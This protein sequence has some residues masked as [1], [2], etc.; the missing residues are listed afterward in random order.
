MLQSPDEMLTYGRDSLLGYAT[1]MSEA[2]QAPPH[3]KRIAKALEAVESGK[4]K[5][6]IVTVPP[7]HG[8]SYLCSTYFPAWY[9]GRNPSKFLIAST[10]GQ[11]LSDDFGRKV[12]D[13]LN[14]KLF[15]AIFP[16]AKLRSDSKAA[17]RFETTSG[18][19]YFGVG[20]GGPITGRG[21]HVLFVDDPVKNR[22][23]ADSVTYREKLWDWYRSVAYTRLMPGG[24][25]VIIMTRWHEDDLVGRI[26]SQPGA[27]DWTVV[28][29]PAVTHDNQPLWPAMYN[30]ASL[31][32]I[33]QTV[34][35]YDWQ[36]LYQ[37]DPIPSEG[38]LI[39]NEWLKS[40]I[41]HA[42]KY[43]CKMVAVD[44][45]IG[46]K[47]TNDET[48]ITVVGVAQGNPA[49]IEEIETLH[50]HY[51]FATTLSLLQAIYHKHKPAMI[52]IEDVAYQKALIQEAA[53]LG[54][55]VAPLSAIKDKV[56]R[57]VSVSHLLSQG[58]VS[59][60]TV[61]LRTQLLRFRGK[62]EANDLADAFFHV[63]GMV[64]DYTEVRNEP[65]AS[66]QDRFKGLSAGDMWRIQT[67]EQR[68]KALQNEQGI[69]EFSPSHGAMDSDFY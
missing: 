29:L 9:M 40:G 17:A 20:A 69:E 24:A 13:Q 16:D 26:L 50:G 63:L 3:L 22:E 47:Q 12:R 38:I 53:R 37:Q 68:V 59:V 61:A 6:L 8:K 62:D 48:A 15:Q 43:T 66:P 31:A 65:N 64:R 5:R 19:T 42:G 23:E 30:L 4:I 21:A 11:D 27:S 55:P 52:G 25:V 18:G 14:D 41:H 34:G 57:A 46:D 44:P 60:N 36:C 49:P 45:A 33:R 7:R 32:D 56:A 2:Y 28:N 39:R 58:R 54:L 1:L 67:R 35:E 51:D 10:Y